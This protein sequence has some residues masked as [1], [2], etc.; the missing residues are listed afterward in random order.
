MLWC[1]FPANYSWIGVW[2]LWKLGWIAIFMTILAVIV[3]AFRNS[4]KDAAD[5]GLDSCKP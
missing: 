2:L 1:A 4:N 5:K 3:N